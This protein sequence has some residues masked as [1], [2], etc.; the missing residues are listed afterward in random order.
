MNC[1]RRIEARSVRK[2]SL[3]S[4]CLPETVPLSWACDLIRYDDRV[5]TDCEL[6]VWLQARTAYRLTADGVPLP[7]PEEVSDRAIGV[8]LWRMIFAL[9]KRSSIPESHEPS[10][11][12]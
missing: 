6:R 1:E 2:P 9:A 11:R 4:V 3:C 5:V 7:P 8:V 12:P 10:L